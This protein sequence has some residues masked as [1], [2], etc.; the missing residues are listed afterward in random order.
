MLFW[1]GVNNYKT[2]LF[3]PSDPNGVGPGAPLYYDGDDATPYVDPA[4]GGNVPTITVGQGF[5]IIPNT[6]CTWTNGLSS[7]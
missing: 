3:D 1:N 7:N 5:F 4:T 6:P 2:C